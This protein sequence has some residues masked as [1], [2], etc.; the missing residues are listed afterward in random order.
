MPVLFKPAAP[1][2]DHAK[3]PPR[4]HLFRHLPVDRLHRFAHI[5][6][7]RRRAHRLLKRLCQFRII[8]RH[9]DSYHSAATP[10]IAPTKRVHLRPAWPPT[11]NES[12]STTGDARSGPSSSSSS[13]SPPSAPPS[14]TGT[15]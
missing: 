14:P 13:S 8:I 4:F 1:P 12:S 5:P 2:R 6:P 15:T 11:L 7:P 3:R 9:I 10:T